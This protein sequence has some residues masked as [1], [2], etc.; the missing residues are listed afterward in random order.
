MNVWDQVP[1]CS[2]TPGHPR[3][4]NSPL[5][6]AKAAGYCK[7]VPLVI[8]DEEEIWIIPVVTKEGKI[9]YLVAMDS[10]RENARERALHWVK[11]QPALADVGE[12]KTPFHVL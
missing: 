2:T 1:G 3:S 11:T 8:T 6:Q 10:S 9:E 4:L 5:L 12:A 7:G